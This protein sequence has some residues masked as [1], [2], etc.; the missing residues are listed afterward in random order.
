MTPNQKQKLELKIKRIKATLAAEKR[1]FGDYDDSRGLRY[2]PL[3]LY[4]KL[5][6][7]RGGLQYA[8]WFSKSFPDDVGFPEFL[9]EWAIILFMN[10]KMKEA[11]RKA[12]ECYF[13]NVYVF[14]KFFGRPIQ[15][16]AG[17]ASYSNMSEPG[18]L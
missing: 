16:I 2:V 3:G 15:S 6:D 1:K 10:G 5:Q 7:Y 4:I 11:E 18:Y 17:M 9:F 8:R 13:R 12:T 14:D